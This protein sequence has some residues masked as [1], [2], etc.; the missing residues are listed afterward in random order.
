MLSAMG[1]MEDKALTERARKLVFEKDLL[2]RNE[3]GPLLGSQ[4]GTEDDARRAELRAWIDQNFDR[5]AELSAPKERRVVS[6]YSA[7]MCSAEEAKDLD[8]KF[9]K[10]MA[11]LEGGPRG[12]AQTRERIQLCSDLRE[13]QSRHPLVI[14]EYKAH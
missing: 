13:A 14:P 8:A 11:S 12:M 2:R 3:L 5:L 10:R 1:N 9:A 6:L 7:N 4:A